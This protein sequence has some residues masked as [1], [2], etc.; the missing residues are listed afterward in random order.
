MLIGTHASEIAAAMAC[1]GY[2]DGGAA[3]INLAITKTEDAL[4]HATNN[5]E[6][7]K[8]LTEQIHQSIIE[9]QFDKQF[10][11][12]FDEIGADKSMRM[13]KCVQLVAGHAERSAE[14]DYQL[15]IQ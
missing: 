10:K 4:K 12:Q 15:D 13:A 6:M 1:K 14:I 2:I 7:A 3:R 11:E 8:H 9:S 5:A